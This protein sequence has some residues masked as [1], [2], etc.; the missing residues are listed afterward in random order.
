MGSFSDEV[1][2]AFEEAQRAHG[3]GSW[4]RAVRPGGA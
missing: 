3:S 1:D 4:R 2:Q